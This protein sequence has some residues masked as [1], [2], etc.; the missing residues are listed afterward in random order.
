VSILFGD[1]DPKGPGPQG[2]DG[3]HIKDGSD[4]TFMADVIEASRTQPV[5]VD[6]WATWC[7]P[8]KQLGPALEKA[9]EAAKGAVKLVKI[10]VDK[11]PA[12]AGQL[13]VQSIPTVYAFLDGKPVDGFQGALPES[14]VKQFVDRLIGPGEPDAVDDILALAAESLKLGDMG[15]AAQAYA[16]ALQLDPGNVKAIAGLARLYLQNGDAER[17]RELLAMAPE[18]TRD[19]ELDS[20][21][22]ALKLAGSASAETAALDQRL[23]ANGDDHEARLELAKVLAGRGDYGRA[24]DELLHIIQRDREWN[25]QAARKQLL[26]VFEAAGA[27]SDVAKQGRKRLSAILF[28]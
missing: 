24:A 22:T 20:I 6:F 7:G 19:A 27:M 21:R 17:A 25:D 3:G 9:V 28:S 11:N 4:A 23:A 12:I 1:T 16:Q 10:D 2:G 5:I 13:R 8:C 18:G 14:Q 15:G 26:E